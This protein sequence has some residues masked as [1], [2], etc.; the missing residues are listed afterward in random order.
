M[1]YARLT[2]GK[3]TVIVI[4]QDNDE[5]GAWAYAVKMKKRSGQFRH[6]N[7]LTNLD[8]AIHEAV[9][10]FKSATLYD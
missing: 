9:K 6:V 5:H 3:T 10:E 8:S 1:E 7:S 4:D 2:N